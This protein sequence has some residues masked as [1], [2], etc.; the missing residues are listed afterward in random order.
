MGNNFTKEHYE[1]IK[2]DPERVTQLSLEDV[3]DRL[4]I[5]MMNDQDNY[6]KLHKQLQIFGS[7]HLDKLIMT[8]IHGN[9]SLMTLFSITPKSEER[10]YIMRKISERGNL[11][12]AYYNALPI[13][14]SKIIMEYIC[15]YQDTYG[16]QEKMTSKFHFDAFT[17][18][19]ILQIC[20]QIKFEGHALGRPEDIF[21]Q[22]ISPQITSMYKYVKREFKFDAITTFEYLRGFYDE[23]TRHVTGI[24]GK[25]ITFIKTN[26]PAV[27]EINEDDLMVIVKNLYNHSSMSPDYISKYLRVPLEQVCSILNINTEV[28]CV[29][30][31]ALCQLVDNHM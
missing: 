19:S 4:F 5:Y 3:N 12:V 10:L 23:S 14:V 25:T 18:K 29:D 9:I 1:I 24:N 17:H 31:D 6:S 16:F 8:A 13:L 22:Y 7:M 2:N 26:Y 20:M 30:K 11:D 27:P 28:P 21:I 15:M